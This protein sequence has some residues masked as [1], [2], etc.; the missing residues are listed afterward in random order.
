MP[1][2][3]HEISGC[4]WELPTGVAA[5]PAAPQAVYE[6]SPLGLMRSLPG[7]G[8]HPPFLVPDPVCRGRFPDPPMKNQYQGTLSNDGQSPRTLPAGA[9]SGLPVCL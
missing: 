7:A 8:R 9:S 3:N 4:V 5:A 2:V 1:I 6:T